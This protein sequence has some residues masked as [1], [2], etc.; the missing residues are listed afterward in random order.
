M[1][2][3]VTR[4]GAGSA[5][6]LLA[7][8]AKL[9][10]YRFDKYKTK[11][12]D[13]DKLLKA[14]TVLTKS[15]AAARKAFA[16]LSNIADGVHLARDLV[17]EPA[18]VLYPEEFAKR[19]RQLSK[20]G[21]KVDVLTEKDMQKLKMD[22]L[23]GV[24]QGSAR[25]SRTVVMQWMGGKKGETPVAFVGKGV[26]FD[27]GGL[28]LKPGAGMGDMKGDMGGAACVTGLMHALAA[29]KARLNVIG[30]IGLAENMPDAAAQRPGDIVNSMSG[31][32]IE[33]LNTDAEGRLLLADVLWYTQKPLQAQVH[34][35]SGHTY[36]RK[37]W[38]RWARSMPGSSPITTN[39]RSV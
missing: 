26:T 37:S 7:S 34:D 30:I 28:S 15:A 5:A 9:R 11:K 19:A 39:W 2:T 18:N 38:L 3:A 24:G 8:G 32:S 16:P 17:N 21:V 35:Q 31:Q 36:R 6:A 4:W 27:S 13:E 22:A 14:L 25:A 33:I 1:T 29:R 23:L 12:K 10:T 20:V